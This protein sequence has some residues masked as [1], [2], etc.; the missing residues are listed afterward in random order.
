MLQVSIN[1]RWKRPAELW[2][3]DMSVCA[4]PCFRQKG[5]RSQIRT[6]LVGTLI[7][8][9]GCRAKKGYYSS[10]SRDTDAESGWGKLFCCWQRKTLKLESLIK[11][12]AGWQQMFRLVWWEQGLQESHELVCGSKRAAS[13]SPPH[14][15]AAASAQQNAKQVERIY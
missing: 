8:V 5:T 9:Q 3:R 2:S 6:K 11:R 13:L 15:Y 10:S 12:D 1:Q 14:E 4:R 7:S